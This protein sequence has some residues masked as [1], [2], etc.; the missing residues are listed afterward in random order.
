MSTYSVYFYDSETDES[1]KVDVQ[2]EGIITAIRDAQHEL[3]KT[4][5]SLKW[6]SWEIWKVEKLF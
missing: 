4:S 1:M 3:T 2:A 5:H 6:M